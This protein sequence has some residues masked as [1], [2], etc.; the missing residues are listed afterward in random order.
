M[1]YIPTYIYALIDPRTDHIRYIGKT[2][3][4]EI[5]LK[6]HLKSFQLSYKTKKNSWIKSLLKNNLKPTFEIIDIINI[7]D[8]SFWEKHYISLYR[9]WGF[10]LTNLDL[11]GY[12]VSTL[13]EETKRKLSILNLGKKQSQ[14]T[15]NKRSIG[16][17]KK[18]IQ[19][20]KDNQ[21]IKEWP[22]IK[23]CGITLNI[24]RGHIS[25]VCQNKLNSIGGFKF[26]YKK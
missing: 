4:P 20:T 15:L 24:N 6:N 1:N 14:E 26:K 21:F 7:N 11:G 2:N 19:L 3:N 16:C 25:T 22:S 23:E 9:S 5:R 8:W 10:N 17:S 18:I 13:S 12:G